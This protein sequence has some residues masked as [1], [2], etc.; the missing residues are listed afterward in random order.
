MQKTQTLTPIRGIFSISFEWS[1][2]FCKGQVRRL[3]YQMLDWL[4]H[5]H[6]LFPC[7][8]HREGPRSELKSAMKDPLTWIA[9]HPAFPLTLWG[10]SKAKQLWPRCEF[11]SEKGLLSSVPLNECQCTGIDWKIWLRKYFWVHEFW[12]IFLKVAICKARII[13]SVQKYKTNL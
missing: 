12:S 1:L 3:D 6:D 10:F 5:E 11:Q 4:S 13:S 8:H 9:I 2:E 7:G